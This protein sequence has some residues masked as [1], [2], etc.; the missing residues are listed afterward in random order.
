MP[1]KPLP[2]FFYGLELDTRLLHCLVAGKKPRI[3]SIAKLLGYRFSWSAGGQQPNL[4]RATDGFVDGILVNLSSEQIQRLEAAR[5][6]PQL[7]QWR[8]VTIVDQ[9]NKRR[10]ARLLFSPQ[11]VESGRLPPHESWARLVDSA[12]DVGLSDAAITAHL[13]ARPND[14]RTPRTGFRSSSLCCQFCGAPVHLAHA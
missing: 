3:I 9:N 1:A 2:V 14:D 8:V 10:R 4:K 12:I 13:Q 6:V 5:L 11:A 7:Y